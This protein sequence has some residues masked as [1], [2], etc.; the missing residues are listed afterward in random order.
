MPSAPSSWVTRFADRIPV[1]GPV[2][3]LATGGGRHGRHLLARGHP[4]TAVDI[5]VTGLDDIAGT[6][7]LEIIAADL[8][9]GPWPLAGRR[10]DGVV[11]A[12]YLWRPI[13][14]DVVAAVAPGG[15]LIYE[16]FALGNEKFGKPS[17][18]DF[19]LRPGELLAAV[20]G[21]LTVIAYELTDER[22]PR[23]A[24]RQRI[25]AIR[26]ET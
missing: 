13:L 4:V 3:D 23:R 11:V 6:P 25:C 2:L 21:V 10:F 19:L 24:M 16:T 1:G 22:V 9:A 8:E 5:D 7:G 17:N 12:N 20:R 15:A 14:P 18:P 26:D